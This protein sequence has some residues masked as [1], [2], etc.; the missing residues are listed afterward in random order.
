MTF[1]KRSHY[2]ENLSYLYPGLKFYPD[3]CSLGIVAVDIA[4]RT[5]RTLT[6]AQ[7]EEIEQTLDYKF[8][9]EENK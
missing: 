8:P 9:G 3:P 7:F 6:V 1:N 4:R 2:A 5:F